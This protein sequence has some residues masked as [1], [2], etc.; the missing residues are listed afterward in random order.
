MLRSVLVLVVA[1]PASCLASWL[2]LN[3]SHIVSLI[4][5]GACEYER[6]PFDLFCDLFIFKL[7]KVL[8][9]LPL[10]IFCAAEALVLLFVLLY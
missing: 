8:K 1:S 2:R 6:P 4:I 7:F 3:V 5:V 9:D 10:L